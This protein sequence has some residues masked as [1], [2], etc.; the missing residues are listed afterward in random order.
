M[1]IR[2]IS[3]N[4]KIKLDSYMVYSSSSVQKIMYML[5][6]YYK[7]ILNFFWKISSMLTLETLIIV[8]YITL[9]SF[10]L[11]MEIKSL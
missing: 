2:M 3:K 10:F 4:L 9:L 1:V 5:L 6:A 7:H 8:I 11:P